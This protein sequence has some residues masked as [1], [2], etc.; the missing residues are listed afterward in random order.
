MAVIMAL[1]LLVGWRT[2]DG[3]VFVDEG[4]A[5]DANEQVFLV[6]V[7][8]RGVC[9]TGVEDVFYCEGMKI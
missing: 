9:L 7:G 1:A 2:G 6:I 8:S 3:G 5:E 4:V